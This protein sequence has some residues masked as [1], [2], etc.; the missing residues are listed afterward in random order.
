M[1]LENKV[2]K[3]DVVLIFDGLDNENL[4][5]K[6]HVHSYISG[7]KAFIIKIITSVTDAFAANQNGHFLKLD[8]F[9]VGIVTIN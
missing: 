4:F 1:F 7:I 9:L 2:V 3:S 5:C 8:N 6:A